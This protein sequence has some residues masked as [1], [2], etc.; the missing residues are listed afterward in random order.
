MGQSIEEIA[1]R[2]VAIENPFQFVNFS[3]RL[4]LFTR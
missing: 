1:F 4:E 2:V 3:V